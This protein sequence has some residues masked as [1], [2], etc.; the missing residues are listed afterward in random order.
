MELCKI[1]ALEDDKTIELSYTNDGYVINDTVVNVKQDGGITVTSAAA[2]PKKLALVYSAQ[3]NK[4]TLFLGDDWERGYGTLEWKVLD[5]KRLMPWYFLAYDG[6]T[7][8]GFGVK[9]GCNCFANWHAF[10]D[11][12]VLILDLRCGTNAVLLNGRTLE[13][14]TVVFYSAQK[15]AFDGACEFCSMLCDNP[16]LPKKPIY[17]GN[18]WYCNYGNNSFDNI[19]ESAEHISMCAKDIKERPFMVIDAGWE[20]AFMNDYIGGPWRY[21]NSKFGDMSKMA[22]AIEDLGV[23]P[24]IWVRP[25]L[26]IEHMPKECLFKDNIWYGENFHLDPSHPITLEYV[27]SEIKAL[28]SYGYKLFKHDYSSCDIFGCFGY[29]MTNNLTPK[30]VT[31]YDNTRTTAEIITDLYRTIRAAVGDDAMIIGCN[32][33]GHLGAGLFELQRTGDDTSGIEW[34]RTKKTGVNTLAFRMCQHNRFFAADADCVGLT[35]KVP[36]EKNS[37]WLDV[38][39]QSG[40]P[41]FVSVA[42]NCRNRKEQNR[43][44][45]EAFKTNVEVANSGKLLKPCD[46]LETPTPCKWERDG[47][48]FKYEW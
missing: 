11:K 8:Y 2:A 43:A 22:Q 21:G 20:L 24:G 36:W 18:D 32:T 7:T 38:L 33:V 6:T 29:D 12:A 48:T 10:G 47:K 41:L 4:N 9:T 42:E 25:L 45:A 15:P 31:F 35:E 23:Q 1:Y 14:A 3:F 13:A 27:T 5:E 19:R 34:S 28:R 44:L 17:G 37:Q 26:T 40:T 46:W 30:P 16:L 39:A